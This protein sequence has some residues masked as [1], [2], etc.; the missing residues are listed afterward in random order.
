MNK[1]YKIQVQK[2]EQLK[3]NYHILR[4]MKNFP[5]E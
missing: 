4:E 5:K 2:T 1:N 3:Y